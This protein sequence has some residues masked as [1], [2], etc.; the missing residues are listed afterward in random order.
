MDAT[1]FR[2]DVAQTPAALRL[3]L[4]GELDLGTVDQ[5]LGAFEAN[6]DGHPEVIVDLS[7]L[8]FMDST[9]IRL[10]LQLHGR[11]DGRRV[12]FADPSPPVARIL[13]LTGIRTIFDWV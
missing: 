13:D 2:I 9:G 11:Q 1:D 6:V 7:G 5:A 3:A 8:T 4:H 10:L 12:R